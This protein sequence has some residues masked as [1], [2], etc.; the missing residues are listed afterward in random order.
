MS[1]EGGEKKKKERRSER[2]WGRRREEVRRGG[3]DRRLQDSYSPSIELLEI[4]R[5]AQH[6]HEEIIS[7]HHK[8]DFKRSGFLDFFSN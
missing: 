3:E 1:V 6:S 8:R 4:Q 7:K 5:E 2:R